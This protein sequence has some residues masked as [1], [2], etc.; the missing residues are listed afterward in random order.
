MTQLVARRQVLPAMREH[1]AAASFVFR[2]MCVA[3]AVPPA[4]HAVR[5]LTVATARAGMAL[6]IRAPRRIRPAAVQ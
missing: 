1:A 6:A 4:K 5:L 2:A 3:P